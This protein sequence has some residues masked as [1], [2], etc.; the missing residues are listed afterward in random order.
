MNVVKTIVGGP[1]YGDYRKQ[2]K[3]YLMAVSHGK[4]VHGINLT[5][6]EPPPMPFESIHFTKLEAKRVLH[7]HNDAIVVTKIVA[8][9]LIRRIQI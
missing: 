5:N 1:E 2:R 6:M 4:I 9:N 3:K 8:N 7:P